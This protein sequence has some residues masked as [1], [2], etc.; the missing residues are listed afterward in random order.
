M[1][2]AHIR[3]TKIALLVVV[4]AAVPVLALDPP[5]NPLPK[6]SQEVYRPAKVDLEADAAKADPPPWCILAVLLDPDARSGGHHSKIVGLWRGWDKA[7][8]ISVLQKVHMAAA[9]TWWVER[10]AGKPLFIPENVTQEMVKVA[11]PPAWA[12][13]FNLP[14]GRLGAE[15]RRVQ[16]EQIATELARRNNFAW[17]RANMGK[18]SEVRRRLQ[19]S[20]KRAP[21]MEAYA[22]PVEVVQP[23]E[24]HALYRPEK[25]P[26]VEK[27]AA[28]EAPPAW[29]L[30]GTVLDPDGR[31]L[32]SGVRADWKAMSAAERAA[33][34]K[35]QFEKYEATWEVERAADKPFF[36]PGEVSEAVVGASAPPVWAPT[37]MNP[38]YWPMRSAAER[39]KALEE[40]VKEEAL[41]R[42]RD[43]DQEHAADLE[44]ARKKIDDAEIARRAEQE[45]LERER[46]EKERLEQER[47]ERERLEREKA[48]AEAAAARGP[49]SD[50]D[51][52]ST[53][54][55]GTPP[56]EESTAGTTVPATGKETPN[57]EPKAKPEPASAAS[58]IVG[59][60]VIA[61]AVVL[62]QVLKKKG[63]DEPLTEPERVVV[64]DGTKRPQN[65]CNECGHTWFPRGS[66]L[67]AVCPKCKSEKVEVV[68]VEVKRFTITSGMLQAFLV[69][70]ALGI[71]GSFLGGGGKSSPKAPGNAAPTKV[72]NG[73]VQDVSAL[74]ANPK[75]G[76]A[77]RGKVV[78]FGAP[79][80]DNASVVLSS[81]QDE[82]KSVDI[83]IPP[84][85]VEKG[86]LDALCE[87]GA[88]VVVVVKPGK[89]GPEL[90]SVGSR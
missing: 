26:A 86:Q 63:A 29:Y 38:T 80:V 37:T 67:S 68:T 59:L 34:L 20:G 40:T 70:L 66:D 36:K 9:E 78:F 56:S 45:R 46:L 48:E 32:R 5:A 84:R 44:A 12:K 39:R 47:L 42:S 8:R 57:S 21:G 15:D 88:T 6:A 55:E 14:W 25:L 69:L 89:D 11:E 10:E 18:L 50:G 87:E 65:T 3:F 35:K 17:D 83:R 51:P 43:W 19:A 77:Y 58:R 60:V 2:R 52:T 61:I 54:S 16:V 85:L 75:K 1:S 24:A 76:G 72:G 90:V 30:W 31:A 49:G 4:L 33:T 53:A 71:V 79:T 62:L 73:G 22:P 74:V 41:T 23:P 64:K 81:L 7:K 82:K 27:L 28:G 13:G